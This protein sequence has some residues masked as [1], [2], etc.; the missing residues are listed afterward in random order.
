MFQG[1]PVPVHA[2]EQDKK[3]DREAADGKGK[4]RDIIEAT[5]LRG[6]QPKHGNVRR[7]QQKH[8]TQ[9]H[10]QR[11]QELRVGSVDGLLLALVQPTRRNPPLLSN[12]HE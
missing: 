8:V 9:H 11:E 3:V 12:R 4:G 5:E 1:L 7:A 10:R 2:L 6:R